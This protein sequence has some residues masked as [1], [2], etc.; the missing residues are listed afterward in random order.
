MG[1]KDEHDKP[2]VVL[3]HGLWTNGMDMTLLRRRLQRYGFACRQFRYHSVRTECEKNVLRLHHFLQAIPAPAIHLVGHS[4]GGLVIRCLFHKYPQQ[5]PG[6]IVTLGTPHQGS[7]V[8]R[9][10]NA[11]PWLRWMLG[12]AVETGLLGDAPAWRGKTELGSIGGNTS[13]GMGRLIPGLPKP[14]DGTV[15]LAETLLPGMTGHI[16]LSL[17][18]FAMLLSGEAAKQVNNF[19]KKGSFSGSAP[20][21]T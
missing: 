8:A 11:R 6:R 19:L 14:N 2:V 4:M 17:A 3:V 10:L 18:H 5:R 7:H 1:L 13:I 12:H 9:F 16:T 21:T 20:D 15:A